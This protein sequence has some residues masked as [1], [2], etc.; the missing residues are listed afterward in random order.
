MINVLYVT[1]NA[2]FTC[3]R[4]DN[5]LIGVLSFPDLF[6]NYWKCLKAKLKH[7]GNELGSVTTQFKFTAPDGKKRAAIKGIP[8]VRQVHW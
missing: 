4:V 6:Y 1:C 7:E 8:V 3:Q 5:G 2:I